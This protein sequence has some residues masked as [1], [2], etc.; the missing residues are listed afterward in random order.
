MVGFV[1]QVFIKILPRISVGALTLHRLPPLGVTQKKKVVARGKNEHPRGERAE[2]AGQALRVRRGDVRG[3]AVGPFEAA[4]EARGSAVGPRAQNVSLRPRKACS[5]AASSEAFALYVIVAG[6][7]RAPKTFF[8]R[9]YMFACS[10]LVR[11]VVHHV[12]PRA[13]RIVYNINQAR[14]TQPGRTKSF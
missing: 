11:I 8:K 7:G 10:R 14:E 12:S 2:E 5:R 13:E 4:Q 6:C 3:H 1:V 9:A